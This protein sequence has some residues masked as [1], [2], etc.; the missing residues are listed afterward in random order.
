MNVIK[1][2]C[3]YFL[4]AMLAE[5]NSIENKANIAIEKKY[6]LKE[7]NLIETLQAQFDQEKTI[8]LE[9]IK[10]VEDYEINKAKQRVKIQN[11]LVMGYTPYSS[12]LL[13]IEKDSIKRECD[14]WYEKVILALEDDFKIRMDIA[15]KQLETEKLAEYN[16]I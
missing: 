15:L 2:W 7:A 14:K 9:Q 1:Q 13:M 4:D 3:N 5:E 10:I 12:T 16:T 11:R 8:L 6:A